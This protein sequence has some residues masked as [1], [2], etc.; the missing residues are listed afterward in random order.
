MKLFVANWKMH[1]T[2]VQASAYAR[3]FGEKIDDGIPGA[4]LVIAPPFTALEAARDREGRWSLAGQNL[5]E[6]AAGAFTGEVSG[7]MLAEAGCRY[8]IVGHSER[9]TLFGEDGPRLAGKLAR[10]RDF[11]LV[12]IYCVGETGAERLAGGTVA[13]LARQLETL[14]DDPA[15]EP[16][17][18]AYEPVWAIGTGLAA[19]PVDAAAAA[20]QIAELLPSRGNLR[21]LYGGSVNPGN[22]A[23]LL[24]R[25]RVDGFLVGGASL[26]AGA[27]AAIA[28]AGAA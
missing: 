19:M 22:A 13:T 5:S 1:M 4:E 27:F 12:P 9:R 14:R 7:E 24:G 2:R 11:G 21:V 6:H 18:V 8:V 16:L 17:V 20:A 10:A 3:D 25:G 28:R 26:D 15:M 23:E